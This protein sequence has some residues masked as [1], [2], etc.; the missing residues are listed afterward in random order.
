MANRKKQDKTF[1]SVQL[2][3]DLRRRLNEEIEGMSFEEEKQF[4]R[5][6]QER[7]AKNSGSDE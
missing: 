5:S 7:A 6:E 4:L 3:R 1:D 2:M